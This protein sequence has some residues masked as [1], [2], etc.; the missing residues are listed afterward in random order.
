MKIDEEHEKV[1]NN[2]RVRHGACFSPL[3]FN[4]YI[5]ISQCMMVIR[6]ADDIAIFA[7]G[8]LKVLL[9]MD[10]VMANLK[11]SSFGKIEFSCSVIWGS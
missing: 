5:E 2:K 7:E 11:S 10:E 1:K 8:T 3:Q 4:L 9:R 6:F